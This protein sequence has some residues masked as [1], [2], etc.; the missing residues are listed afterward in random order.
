MPH[1][2]KS[3]QNINSH[4]MNY[5]KA[6]TFMTTV[7]IKNKTLSAPQEVC[8]MPFPAHKRPSPPREPNSYYYCFRAYFYSLLFLYP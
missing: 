4:F 2:E 8:H 6:D 3:A 7:Y 1:I 5:Y